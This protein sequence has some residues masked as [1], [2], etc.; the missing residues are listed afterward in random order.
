MPVRL[1]PSGSMDNEGPPKGG[2]SSV[3]DPEGR[4]RTGILPMDSR[5]LYQLSYLGVVFQM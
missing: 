2:P 5:S 4:I 1:R 3:L